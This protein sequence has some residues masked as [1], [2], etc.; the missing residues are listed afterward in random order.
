MFP[1]IV[2]LRVA[3]VTRGNAVFCLGLRDLLK[4]SA[5]IIPPRLRITRLQKATAAATA[6]IIGPIRGHIHKVLFTHDG[7]NNHTK[8]LGHWISERFTNQ[9]T[10]ILYR[11]FDTQFI[12]PAGIDIQFSFA[13]PLGIILNDGFNLE[14]MFD[15]ELVQSDPD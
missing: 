1:Q 8:I 3:V 12:V 14:F 13:Y 10:G 11:K 9:L 2:N 7:L 15:V 4:L 6:I 5:S